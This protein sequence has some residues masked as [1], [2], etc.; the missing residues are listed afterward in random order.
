MAR[1]TQTGFKRGSSILRREQERGEHRGGLFWEILGKMRK[2]YSCNST[3]KRVS[4]QVHAE[5]LPLFVRPGP[6]GRAANHVSCGR[7]SA[8]ECAA[9]LGLI[10][11]RLLK[12]KLDRCRA[13]PSPGDM[14][15]ERPCG[16]GGQ[17]REPRTQKRR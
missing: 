5:S 7:R 15:R 11:I 1:N 13:L 2:L 12:P 9:Q 14:L 10:K 8:G 16:P 4:L 6:A 3:K 17:S